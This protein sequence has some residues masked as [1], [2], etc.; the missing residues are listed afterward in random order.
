MLNLVR[1]EVIVIQRNYAELYKNF[2]WCVPM[3]YYNTR[4][5]SSYVTQWYH[6]CNSSHETSKYCVTA[7]LFSNEEGTFMR[8]ETEKF[9][10][11]LIEA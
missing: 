4:R 2:D 3:I 11:H 1:A 8:N 9:W 5:H 10:C 6:S 7:F